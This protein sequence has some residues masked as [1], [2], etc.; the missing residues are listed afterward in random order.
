MQENKIISLE[1]RVPVLR[2]KKRKKANLRILVTILVF[3]SLLLCV[4]YFQTSIGSKI[5]LVINGNQ[6]YSDKEIEKLADVSVDDS[7]LTIRSKRVV[8]QL[9]S[10][11]TIQ[12][13]IVHK[14]FPNKVEI[15]VKEF[16]P[17]GQGLFS[18]KKYLLLESG[19]LIKEKNSLGNTTAPD[20]I[21]WKQGDEL[22]EMAAELKKMPQSIFQSISEI[23]YTPSKD[24]PLLITVFTNEGYEV[25][26][27]IRKFSNKMSNYPLILKS[28]PK[29]QKGVI[30]LEVG[31]Y[32]S[33]YSTEP[34]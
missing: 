6:L 20:L 22:Q 4:L 1:D 9:E 3:F 31:A 5:H 17:V 16:Q 27:T 21:G 32:F 28:I 15:D 2:N 30:H 8:D 29:D 26:T 18:G 34:K 23:D 24:D 14:R 11:N 7:F 25:R 19:V 33:P 12:S 10:Q 13:A